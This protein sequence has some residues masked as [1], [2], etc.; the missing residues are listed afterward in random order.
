MATYSSMTLFYPES[1]GV[2]SVLKYLNILLHL[3]WG[4]LQKT[5]ILD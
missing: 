4:T 5:N 1:F 3:F 2:K